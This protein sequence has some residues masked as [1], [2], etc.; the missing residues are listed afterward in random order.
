MED[1]ARNNDVVD[2]SVWLQWY[3][4]DAIGN[5]T[6]QRKFGFME[7]KEDVDEMIEG[8]DLG[9][10][11]V[12]VIGQFPNLHPYIMG[13][14]FWMFF[15][16][17]FANLK[18][19][20]SKFMVIT[21]DQ[22]TLYDNDTDK[23]QRTDFLAQIRSKKD[24]S[25]RMTHRDE[26]NHLSNNLLAGSDTTAISL[27]ACFY[28]LIKTPHAY[29][30]L[31]QEIF[32]ANSRGRL[33]PFVTYDE[34]LHLP[35]L[36]SVIKEALRMHPGVGFPLERYVPSGG[37]ILCGYFVPAGT[38]VSISAPVIHQNQTIFGA[39]AD[40]FRP[41]RWIEAS[42]EQLKIMDRAMLHFGYGTRTCIGK[43]I[44]LME[45]GKFI[46]QVLRHFHLQW[47]SPNTEWT[48]NAAW[49]W[50]QSDILHF[51]AKLTQLGSKHQP[52][53]LNQPSKSDPPALT[54]AG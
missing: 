3:A 43:N 23:H 36:Q 44:S 20:L 54:M 26:M 37:R 40:T 7:R 1:A 39:D 52:N 13:N 5:I 22:I 41:E 15:L 14:R 42:A 29:E 28:Y 12:K 25:G 45:M 27:R 10:Q 32:E 16:K 33:S 34:S 2:L 11:Y 24:K 9:L 6:F 17:R 30:K 4:F 47:A 51:N 53:E 31:V 18:D 8:I 46:P 50:K 21:A 49:F 35:Y 48:T 38:N 19:T